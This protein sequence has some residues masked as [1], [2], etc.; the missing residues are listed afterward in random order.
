MSWPFLITLGPI[1]LVMYVAVW[2]VAA[3]DTCTSVTSSKKVVSNVFLPGV[4]NLKS[5]A[6]SPV[7]IQVRVMVSPLTGSELEETNEVMLEILRTM[8]PDVTV[9]PKKLFAASVS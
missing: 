3:D 6:D 9:A 2:V 1:A 5:G 8:S 7:A 4:V